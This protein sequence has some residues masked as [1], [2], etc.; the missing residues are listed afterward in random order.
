MVQKRLTEIPLGE[1]LEK[2]PYT[3]DIALQRF[4]G[5]EE[6]RIRL[7]KLE[8]ESSFR[9]VAPP[10][11][12]LPFLKELP[13]KKRITEDSVK[14]E[15]FKLSERITLEEL[16][17]ARGEEIPT[18]AKRMSHEDSLKR[19]IDIKVSAIKALGDIKG[20]EIKVV[21]KEVV[22]KGQIP[23][24]HAA[25]EALAGMGDTL[26]F[27]VLKAGLKKEDIEM[28]L[29]SIK[30]LGRVGAKEAAPE[31]EKLLLDKESKVSEEA[32]FAL[33]KSGEKKGLKAVH[34][35]LGS[36]NMETKVK[37]AVVLAKTKDVV[38]VP[39]LKEAV[40]SSDAELRY[41]A[42]RALGDTKDKSILPV[43]DK[44]VREDKDLK[45]RLGASESILKLK[46]E[47][48]R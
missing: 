48:G 38:A 43:L 30:A 23:E 27:N 35:L 8:L 9:K 18:E 34:K 13:R 6:E 3:R 16:L 31:L 11:T 42:A 39:I 45:V 21:L 44:L 36:D 22:D 15:E 12:D 33:A 1:I 32:A 47:E 26:G 5:S 46:K 24:R 40:K 29:E 37:A 10:P 20:P 4:G 25:A 17:I 7:E 28:K 19:T 2:K 14:R 41:K